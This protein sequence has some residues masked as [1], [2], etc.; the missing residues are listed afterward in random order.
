[1]LKSRIKVRT[2]LSFESKTILAYDFIKLVDDTIFR[3]N[4]LKI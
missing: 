4:E 3:L 1:M 2:P